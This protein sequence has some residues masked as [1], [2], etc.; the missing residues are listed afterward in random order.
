MAMKLVVVPGQP[1]CLHVAPVSP[2]AAAAAAAAAAVDDAADADAAAA[3]AADADACARVPSGTCPT[4]ALSAALE[5]EEV[6][7]I[8]DWESAGVWG[9]AEGGGEKEG[10]SFLRAHSATSVTAD[11]CTHQDASAHQGEDAAAVVVVVGGGGGASDSRTPRAVCENASLSRSLSHAHSAAVSASEEAACH[12]GPVDGMAGGLRLDTRL[13]SPTGPLL[14][15]S[16]P[17]SP[18]CAWEGGVWCTGF[19]CCVWGLGVVCVVGWDVAGLGPSLCG[20]CVRGWLG[21]GVWG[22]GVVFGVHSGYH[23]G[24]GGFRV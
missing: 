15:S 12:Q 3:D 11:Y 24:I 13:A 21:C 18:V 7:A 4:A 5:E 20:I 19:G 17:M 22:C 14:S 16:S 6:V 9:G 8:K 1:A 23:F 10:V 2:V